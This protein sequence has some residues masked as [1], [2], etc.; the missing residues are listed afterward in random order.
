MGPIVILEQPQ[1]GESQ[2]NGRIEE[3][4]TTRRGVPEVLKDKVEYA[5]TM[6]GT[7]DDAIMQWLLR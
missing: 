2:A 1:K 3:A 5:T 6:V 4:G 7:C